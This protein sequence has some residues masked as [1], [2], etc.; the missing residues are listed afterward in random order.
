[1]LFA[2]K[3]LYFQNQFPKL[4]TTPG[5][6]TAVLPAGTYTIV[7]RGGG[8][9]GGNNGQQIHP[10]VLPGYGGAGAPGTIQS[11]NVTLGRTT[12]VNLVV[13]SGGVTSASGG[14]GGVS[15]ANDNG[16][17]GGSGGGGGHASYVSFQRDGVAYVSSLI[18][19]G[20]A[21]GGGGGGGGHLGRYSDGG[22][23]GAGGGSYITT[24]TTNGVF[25]ETSYPGRSATTHQNNTVGRAGEA[26]YSGISANIRSGA[27]IHGSRYGWAGGAAAWYAGASGGSGSDG[28]NEVDAWSGGGGGGAGGS[29]YAGGGGGGK[30]KSS[31][32]NAEN[33]SNHFTTPVDTTSENQSYGVNGNY[34]RGGASNSAGVNGFV[35]IKR[36]S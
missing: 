14:N 21:G 34:G 7:V 5:T 13:G 15:V 32:I 22:G 27:G 36:V 26:G 12:L 33:A 19:Q 20:G 11:T 4:Y 18:G 1:M 29:D 6:Y 28:D 24:V 35:F 3:L 31:S 9:C 25:S 8:G 2:K 16:A 10:N 17:V 23:G 30:T